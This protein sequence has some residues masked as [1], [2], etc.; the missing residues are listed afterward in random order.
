MTPH[1][2]LS[3]WRE[4]WGK[5]AEAGFRRPYL[6]GK[7]NTLGKRLVSARAWTNPGASLCILVV[8]VALLLWMTTFRFSLGGQVAFSLCIV[9][10]VLYLQRF[11]GTL[12]A[13]TLLALLI[14]VSGRYFLWRF[15]STLGHGFNVDFLLG[16][17]LCVAE[18]HLWLLGVTQYLRTVWPSKQR[19]VPLPDSQ[20]KWPTVDIYLTT[21]KQDVDAVRQFCNAVLAMEW[22]KSKLRVFVLDGSLLPA[23][24]E[25]CDFLH[26]TYVVDSDSVA[27]SG[28]SVYAALQRSQGELAVIFDAD[29][30][31]DRDFLKLTVGW[32]TQNPALGCLQSTARTTQPSSTA[33][34]ILRRSFLPE[35]GGLEARS[36]LP[37]AAL[38]SHL[39]E[40]G[41]CT[42]EYGVD[43]DRPLAAGI[44]RTDHSQSGAKPVWKEWLAQAH[45]VLKFY[46]PVA[47][48][49]IL[50]APTAYLLAGVHLIQSQAEWFAAY[51]TPHF[52]NYHMLK[53]RQRGLGRL[54]IW[55][56]VRH[57]ALAWYLPFATLFSVLRVGLSA[58]KSHFRALL[59]HLAAGGR[60]TLAVSA[61]HGT[62]RIWHIHFIVVLGLNV[63]GLL[64]AV[65]QVTWS[66][67]VNSPEP[68]FYLGWCLFNVA[69]LISTVA[70]AKE[71][72]DIQKH[73][74]SLACLP[75]MV[76]L[77]SGHTLRC[78]TENFPDQTLTL[79]FPVELRLE[80]H[81]EITLSIFYK[82]REFSF[83]AT[84]K[85]ARQTQLHICIDAA[86]NAAYQHAAAV[87]FSRG[88]DWP[89]WLP[90][91]DA[92]N[93]LP[94]WLTS[95]LTSC[96]SSALALIVKI[97]NTLHIAR[98]LRWIHKRTL[99]L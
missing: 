29:A 27:A 74:R 93:P 72:Q 96:I 95:R 49:I 28:G 34:V 32:F 43:A 85:S 89:N 90:G 41:Y 63:A 59:I 39:R 51:A 2:L 77:P 70:V 66:G 76:R 64:W 42:A 65:R 69:I 50:T 92:D 54:P 97:G 46:Q 31:P 58:L 19:T 12:I 60:T 3:L 61:L 88:F 22:P 30:K 84:V 52:L 82:Q 10:F 9:G 79:N 57:T 78:T 13:L 6:I 68:A 4:R 86:A 15:G 75:A 1:L 94:R 23:I 24:Q 45:T 16:F 35:S 83:S 14:L 48:W 62:Q 56:M 80:A 71:K 8:G 38:S 5:T 67:L 99:A 33:S 87:V 17:G 53:I 18:L 37:I 73:M 7:P 36:S 81:S 11:K 40:H 26:V 55:V 91:V 44:Y 20:G 98:L 25:L 21:H 47:L